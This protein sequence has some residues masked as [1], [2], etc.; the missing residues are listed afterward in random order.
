MNPFVPTYTRKSVFEIEDGF[1]EKNNISCVLLDIDNTLVAD[2]DPYPD[3]KATEFVSRLKSSEL[4][5]CLV[6]N[7]KIGRVESFNSGFGL[8]AIHR[9]HKPFCRKLNRAIK[10]LDAKKSETLLIGDQLLTDIPAGNF[11]GIRTM[12]VN[13]INP[14]KENLF[15]K[16]KRFIENYILKRN[17]R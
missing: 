5:I 4:K 10:E 17:F 15:F 11:A 3:E 2:N 13:P 12:L 16:F 14:G 6:S 7:N 1:F 9:A 8:K